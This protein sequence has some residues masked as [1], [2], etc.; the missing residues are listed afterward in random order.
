M[1]I[2]L[3]SRGW[4]PS[5]RGGSE[6]FISKLGEELSRRGHE[7]VGVTR[8]FHGTEYPK[9][10]HK[11]VV[12]EEGRA[13]PLLSSYLFSRWAAKVVN[14]LKPDAVITNTYWG[15]TS[16]L[17]I[18]REIPV[19]A[20]IHDVGLIHSEWARKHRVKHALRMRALRKVTQRVDK[21]VVPTQQ[22]KIDLTEYFNVHPEK[23]R[24]LGFEGVSGPFKRVLVENEYFDLLQVGRF[25]PNKGQTV[26]LEA[27][28]LVAHEIPDLKLWL[29]GGKGIDPEHLMYLEKVRALAKE[30]NEGV[31]R[32]VV[33]IVV[34]APE[35]SEYY[36]LADACVMSSIGEE[37]Y[38]LTVVECMAYGKPV[39]ASDVFKETG[40]ASEERAFIYPRGNARELAKLILHV[41]RNRDDAL[42]KAEKGLEYAREC[43]WGRVA[44][45]FEEEIES[46]LRLKGRTLS[47]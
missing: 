24:V 38:G 46:V 1:R 30:I 19:I 37:G 47:T 14:G 16:P 45:I 7:V 35:V 2:A 17:M 43:S 20:V 11:L 26:T 40:V 27:V 10:P 4:W 31:G 21:I 18:S 15:E 33:K 41:Y 23:I 39:I 44:E 42:A 13:V 8:W 29:V 3:V 9:A 6:R 32:E 12:K 22:V 34:D 25:A 36:E 5:V 28:K